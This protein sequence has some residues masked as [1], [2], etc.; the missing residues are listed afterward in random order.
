MLF[1]FF[2][3][4]PFI[5][6]NLNILIV[7]I[8]KCKEVLLHKFTGSASIIRVPSAIWNTR[9]VAAIVRYIFKHFVYSSYVCFR[10]KFWA[11]KMRIKYICKSIMRIQKEAI[12]N[13]SSV[14]F[15]GI[16][17]QRM[18]MYLPRYTYR[19]VFYTY[20]FCY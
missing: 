3:S 8:L 7:H 19:R 11:S 10:Q 4:R 20:N 6:V 5:A 12:W 17:N 1:K 16:S 15:S 14:S 2:F 18:Y 9:F 13:D